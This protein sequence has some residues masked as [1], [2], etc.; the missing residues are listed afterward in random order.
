M[1]DYTQEQLKTMLEEIRTGNVDED[2]IRHNLHEIGM[3][4][5]VDARTTVESF[6]I[7]DN[8]ELRHTAL[9]V[10]VLDWGLID[11]KYTAERFLFGDSESENR[12]LG[13]VC[14]GALLEGTRDKT[15]LRMLIAVFNNT[16]E[17]LF[18]RRGAYYAIWDLWGRSG[19]PGRVVEW[20]H[21]HPD[22][23]PELIDSKIDWDWL[24]EVEAYLFPDA[25]DIY[26]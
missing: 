11:H 23:E 9:S 16:A 14:L 19:K 13:A 7:H 26:H 1:R 24:R 8:E 17:K 10:L 15:A 3:A 2:R 12:S 20:H 4:G 5:F 18:V 6:L 21:G 22:R 25:H